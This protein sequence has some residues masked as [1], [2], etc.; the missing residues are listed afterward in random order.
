MNEDIIQGK[1]LEIKG[2]VKQ[3][4]GRLTDNDLVEIDGQPPAAGR[5]NPENLWA[6]AGRSRK[7]AE[8]MGKR[9]CGLR[10][11]CYKIAHG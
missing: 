7:A 11:P 3:R 4:W 10:S 1:W 9:Y 2:A 6:G 8:G 5:K